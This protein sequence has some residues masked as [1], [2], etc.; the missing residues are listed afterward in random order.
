M[1]SHKKFYKIFKD[2]IFLMT[3]RLFENIKEK[4]SK[5]F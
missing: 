1:I 3:H 4:T 2:Q 5:F